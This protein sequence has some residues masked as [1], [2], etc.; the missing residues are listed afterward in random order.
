M[1]HQ[2]HQSFKE[3]NSL[4]LLQKHLLHG[5][6]LLR[7]G[8]KSYVVGDDTITVLIILVQARVSQILR[9]HLI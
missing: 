4:S 9:K 3:Q 5:I 6:P 1:T 8:L 7:G 2:Q